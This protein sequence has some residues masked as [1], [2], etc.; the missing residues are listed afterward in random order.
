[1]GID[2]SS[3]TFYSTTASHNKWIF[4]LRLIGAGPPSAEVMCGHNAPRQHISHVR[5]SC[6]VVI[7]PV[8]PWAQAQ[9]V[10]RCRVWSV[11]RWASERTGA[12]GALRAPSCSKRTT[13]LSK[14]ICL[15]E[16]TLLFF[17]FFFK[18]HNLLC[19]G[20]VYVHLPNT[21]ITSVVITFSF[22]LPFK[23]CFH[24]INGF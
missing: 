1:M 11:H 13:G 9:Q 4:R 5:D 24:Y 16:E 10:G 18:S 21:I 19:K 15:C 23:M 12:T 2:S 3:H 22:C 17:L 8:S 14:C 7:E 6:G 20:L